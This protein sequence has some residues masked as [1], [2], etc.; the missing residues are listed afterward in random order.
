MNFLFISQNVG[1]NEP[2]DYIREFKECAMK[3]AKQTYGRSKIIDHEA[4]IG[5]FTPPEEV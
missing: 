2:E 4:L 5:I 3:M 1:G